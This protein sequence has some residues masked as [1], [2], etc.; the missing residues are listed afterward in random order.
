VHGQFAFAG[1][2]CAKLIGLRA[3]RACARAAGPYTGLVVPQL[4][5]FIFSGASAA[6]PQRVVVAMLL[7]AVPLAGWWAFR[8]ARDSGYEAL[9]IRAEPQLELTLTHLDG[10]LRRHEQLVNLVEPNAPML[11]LLTGGRAQAREPVNRLLSRL[12]E[13]TGTRAIVLVDA[14]GRPVA[15]SDWYQGGASLRQSLAGSELLRAAGQQ[16]QAGLFAA[17]PD[18]NGDSTEYHFAQ[19]VRAGGEV[20]GALVVQVNLGSL[21]DAWIEEA[22]RSDSYRVAVIDDNDVV[23][24]ASTPG[25]KFQLARPAALSERERL[26]ESGRYRDQIGMFRPMEVAGGAA[27]E[28]GSLLRMTFRG[29][30]G[31]LVTY[32]TQERRLA[33]PHARVVLFTDASAVRADALL[34]AGGAG[35]AIT[36]AGVLCLYGLQLRRESESRRRANDELERRVAART[37]ELRLSNLELV[38]EIGER[39]KAEAVL[40]EAQDEL[41]QAAKMAFLGQMAAG[42]AHEI[43][44]PLMAMRALSDNARVLLERGRMEE[45]EGNLAQIA[46]LTQRMG[47]ITSQL[48]SFARKSPAAGERVDVAACVQSTLALMDA[49][50]RAERVDLAVAVPPLA[51]QGDALRLEQVLANLVANAIDA[52]KGQARARRLAIEGD[53]RGADVV[54]RV[55][56]NGPGIAPPV[57]ARLFEPFFSTKP[58]GEGLGLGLVISANIVREAGGV[59]RHVPSDEG[60]VFEIAL[61]P[62]EEPSR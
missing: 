52:M 42:V 37:T 12:A 1:G 16:G 40:R 21:E 50:L 19:L 59:L 31:P 58:Q 33:R 4:P 28:G 53:M 43:N 7:V 55:A 49:R 47:R 22:A 51:A 13:A 48:K 8:Q 17:G 26:R 3:I 25:M 45:V 60:A 32:L 36:L 10:V 24:L 41:V 62:W 44:Q 54:L 61:K 20:L 18:G 6:T 30:S 35:L 39:E 9:A 2:C 46:Q 38:R 5:R 29:Q 56:D 11:E 27:V 57:A 15:A 23:V 14:G 34:A